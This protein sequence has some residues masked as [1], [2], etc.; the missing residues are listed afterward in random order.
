ME[1]IIS[2][3]T[4]RNPQDRFQSAEELIYA[5]KHYKDLDISAFSKY[6]RKIRLFSATVL[7]GLCFMT[8]SLITGLKANM[9]QV[10]EYGYLISVADK[11]ATTE[12]ALGYYQKAIA[13]DC[14]K[15]E[16]YQGIVECFGEDGIF[17]EAEEEILVK[18]NI[19][20]DKYLV[21]FASENPQEYADFCYNV[22]N[23]YW[24]YYVHEGNRQSNAVNW[25]QT[26]MEYYENN[27]DKN[28]EWKR[29]RLYVEIGTFYKKILLAQIEGTDTG[30]Y[31]EYW[32]NLM[33]LKQ[34]N[35]E[36]P[37]GE[38][39]TLRLYREIVSRTAEYAGYLMEDGVT[40]KEIETLLQAIRKDMQEME[41]GAGSSIRQEIS[42]I[43]V[44][45]EDAE[46][47][48]A[49]G[50]SKTEHTDSEEGGDG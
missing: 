48:V 41:K 6:K 3:C 12:D 33:E 43:N 2:K 11:S 50:S 27:K 45:L 8:A 35:D 46:N 20:V 30:M 16:A 36:N 9:K 15:G 49:S 37:D 25:F 18:L 28:T 40:Q 29:S 24:F 34:F 21:R 5:L 1:H 23:L 26:A 47:M 4:Q 44:L 19:S 14:T 22:G 39:T 7:T 10:S 38:M 13:M 42:E 31:S 32:N 17:S